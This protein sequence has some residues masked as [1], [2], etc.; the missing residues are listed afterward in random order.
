MIDSDT[1]RA[2]FQALPKEVVLGPESHALT[3]EY[4][5]AAD[6]ST[7][8]R[9]YPLVVTLRYYGDR[10]DEARTPSTRLLSIS[11]SDEGLA[12]LKGERTLETLSINVHARSPIRQTEYYL[13]WVAYFIDYTAEDIIH[14]YLDALQVWILRDLPK[15]IGVDGRSSVSDLSYLEEGTQRRQ[16]D[17]YLKSSISWEETVGIV[18][19]VDPDVAM[20]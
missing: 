1:R 5:S 18:E 19:T 8:L 16:V 17:V 3:V 15:I 20:K 6:V 9:A 11:S 13:P 12:Y 10:T 4:A 2:I 7:L 14:A